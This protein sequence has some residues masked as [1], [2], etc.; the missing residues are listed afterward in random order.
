[1]PEISRITIT[2]IN[3]EPKGTKDGDVVYGSNDLRIVSTIG[4]EIP[5]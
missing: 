5:F 3:K 4:H 2:W 1:M